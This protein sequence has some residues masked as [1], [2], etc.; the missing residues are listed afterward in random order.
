MNE[1]LL[2][3][4]GR[5]RGGVNLL[6][7][8]VWSAAGSCA[9]GGLCT[10]RLEKYLLRIEELPMP[11]PHLGR[12]FCG[13]RLAHISDLHCSP[14]VRDR[15]LHQCIEVVNSLNVDFVAVTGDMLTGPRTYARRVAGVLRELQPNVATLA[16]LGNHDYGL[17]HPSGLGGVRDLARYVADE[18]MF[19]DVFVLTNESRIFRRNGSALQFVGVEDYW[20]PQFDPAMAFDLIHPDVPT[21]ALCHNPDG[22]REMAARGADWVLAGHTHGNALPET[23]V[24][25]FVLP[26]D[27]PHFV[28]GT[29]LLQDRRFLYVNRG[30][31]YARRRNLNSRPEITVFT[32]CRME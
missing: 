13:T 26:K 14:I 18:L 22:A 6:K 9:L 31:G 2:G 17:W 7:K 8:M 32:L 4:S 24:H 11:I 27:Q 12:E 21:I 3:S 15:Y 10:W 19:A 1:V 29:Y 30:L 28:A 23:R 20:T 16:C 5:R 25:G